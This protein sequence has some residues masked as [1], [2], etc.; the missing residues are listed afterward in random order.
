MI[1]RILIWLLSFL[2]TE[3]VPQKTVFTPEMLSRH[4]YGLFIINN[5]VKDVKTRPGYAATVSW[6]LTWQI[7]SFAYL[8]DKPMAKYGLS[9]FLTDGWFHP[10][11]NTDEDVCKWLNDNP[12]G[13]EYRVMTPA[14]V[15]YII[16]HRK[17]GFL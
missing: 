9:N 14:E 8:H 1:N 3:V 17:Q 5:K 2:R 7:S 4:N 6:K 15:L 11:G 12:N 10:I 16:S 13:Q